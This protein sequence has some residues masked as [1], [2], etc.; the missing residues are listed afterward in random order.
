MR[1]SAEDSTLEVIGVA[2]NEKYS[3][4]FEPPTPFLYLPFAQHQRTQMSLLVET[5]NADAP[6]LAGPLREVTREI[7]IRMAIGAARWDVLMMVLRQGLMLSVAGVFVGGLLSLAVAR[8]PECSD[9][10]GKLLSG[11]SSVESRPASRPSL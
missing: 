9:F 4:N 10:A 5:V 2:R 8:L 3:F 6:A 1:L 11:S 7:G